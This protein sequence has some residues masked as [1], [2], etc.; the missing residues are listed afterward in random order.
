M[1]TER[2]S[3]VGVQSLDEWV[4]NKNQYEVSHITAHVNPKSPKKAT[5]QLTRKATKDGGQDFANLEVKRQSA[6]WITSPAKSTIISEATFSRKAARRKPILTSA[7]TV[8]PED[9]EGKAST[10]RILWAGA[11]SLASKSATQ[12]K[13]KPPVKPDTD[14]RNSTTV[15]LDKPAEM[16]ECGESKDLRKVSTP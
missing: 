7:M 3:P 10:E 1:I 4:A 14:T 12:L 11:G 15:L 16:S 6:E 2:D 9:P 8:V 13:P 5:R